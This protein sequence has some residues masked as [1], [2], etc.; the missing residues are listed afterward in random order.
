LYADVPRARTSNTV[1]SSRLDLVRL[2]FYYT[3]DPIAQVDTLFQIFLDN[4]VKSFIIIPHLIFLLL[5][6]QELKF[7]E[8]ALVRPYSDVI[9]DF[10]D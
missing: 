7:C 9:E 5:G 6:V 10:L 3:L 2:I 8:V 1:E 4:V